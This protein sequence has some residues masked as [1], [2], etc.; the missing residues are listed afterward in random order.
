LTFDELFD[1]YVTTYD[2][3]VTFMAMLE[4]AKTRI[5]RL[6]QTEPCA[7]IYLEHALVEGASVEPRRATVSDVAPRQGSQPRDFPTS[8]EEDASDE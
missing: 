1:G 5:L 4:M 3:V 2:L 8:N 6:F 7:P